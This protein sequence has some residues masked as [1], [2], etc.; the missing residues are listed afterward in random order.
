MGTKPQNEMYLTYFV[1]NSILDIKVIYLR[2]GL[3]YTL[4][5]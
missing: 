5:I 3:T 1:S 4:L 2:G